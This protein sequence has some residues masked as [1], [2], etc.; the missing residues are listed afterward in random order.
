[1]PRKKGKVN[2]DTT[3]TTVKKKKKENRGKT[4]GKEKGT[5]VFRRISLGQ[6]NHIPILSGRLVGKQVRKLPNRQRST[7]DWEVGHS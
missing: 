5:P 4:T 7:K 6:K 3:L 2:G 1:V